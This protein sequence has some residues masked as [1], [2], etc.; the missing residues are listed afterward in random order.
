MNGL[1]IAIVV[2]SVFAF[3]GGYRRGLVARIVLWA[4]VA[5]TM[6]LAADNMSPLLRLVHRGEVDPSAHQIVLVVVASLFVGRLIGALAGHWVRRRIPTRP[7]RAADRLAGGTTGVL[8]VA[9]TVWLATPILAF[10]PGWPSGAV[11]SSTLAA[12]LSRRVPVRLDALAAVRN[13]LSNSGYPIAVSAIGRSFDAGSPPLRTVVA[14]TVRTRV[15]TSVVRVTSYGCGVESIGSGFIVRP[16]QVLTAAHV[17]AGGQAISVQSG[18]RIVPAT[19]VAFDPGADLALLQLRRGELRNSLR[20]A[21]D[22]PIASENESDNETLDTGDTENQGEVL[23]FVDG[24]PLKARSVR[25]STELSEIGRDI[26]DERR[27]NR[28]VLRLAADLGPG[29]SGAPVIDR[30]GAVIG[31][32]FSRAPDRKTTAFALATSEIRRFLADPDTDVAAATRCLPG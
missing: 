5:G 26:F 23:G 19:I 9:I 11:R 24:G 22:Y 17:L 20:L 4:S 1:D 25:S 10:L 27:V 28:K 14:D 30:N 13:L 12:N 6:L 21:P 3:V 16:D 2:G 7:L 18:T 29:D 31:L 32:V 8:G 15:Q